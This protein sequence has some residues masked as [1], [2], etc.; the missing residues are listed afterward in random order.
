MTRKPRR[1]FVGALPVSSLPQLEELL[2]PFLGGKGSRGHVVMVRLGDDSVARLD[3]LVESGIFGSRSEAAAFLIGAGVQAQ[4]EL[5]ERIAMQTSE[6]KRL[7]TSLRE[8]A[9]SALGAVGGT[10]TRAAAATEA[11]E[12]PLPT[13]AAAAPPG[14]SGRSG[15]ARPGRRGR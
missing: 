8:T 2:A 7:R 12:P 15:R 1:V 3:D 9:L 11:T 4:R 13:P 10:R 14:P 5:F 6:I